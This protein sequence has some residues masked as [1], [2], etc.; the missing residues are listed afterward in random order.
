MPGRQI[1]FRTG[2]PGR[3]SIS[4]LLKRS[5]NT[6]LVWNK[7][8][9]SSTNLVGGEEWK[10][11]GRTLNFPLHVL[12]PNV[13]NIQKAKWLEYNKILRSSLHL[14][15]EFPETFHH[16]TIVI[17]ASY[18]WRQSDTLDW[19][20]EIYCWEKP[21]N[22]QIFTLFAIYNFYMQ[23]LWFWQVSQS[24]S[25]AKGV[26]EGCH[27]STSLRDWLRPTKYTHTYIYRVPQCMSLHWNWDSP[28]PSLASD[29]A[30]PPN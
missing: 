19:F 14:R 18:L 16:T 30:P 10:T 9:I 15:P 4:G 17:F 21:P 1:G 28:T 2:P 12:F 20:G 22:S 27:K 24:F 13:F 25:S 29:C 11:T 26:D 7:R 6:A 23:K 5:T 8:E 3:E